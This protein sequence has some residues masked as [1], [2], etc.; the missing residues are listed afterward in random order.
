MMSLYLILMNTTIMGDVWKHIGSICWSI[1]KLAAWVMVYCGVSQAFKD[2]F[3]TFLVVFPP[4]RQ[5]VLN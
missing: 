5:F 3:K 4:A 1:T 2:V